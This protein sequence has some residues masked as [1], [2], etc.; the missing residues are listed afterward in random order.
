[1]VAIVSIFE[2]E[3]NRFLEFYKDFTNNFSQVQRLWDTFD[4]TRKMKQIN[5]SKKFIYKK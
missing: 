4:K 3:M 1:L 5:N 2:T